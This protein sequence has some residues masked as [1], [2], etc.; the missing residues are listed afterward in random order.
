MENGRGC[1]S[2]IPGDNRQGL[3]EVAVVI[4]MVTRIRPTIACVAFL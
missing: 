1:G 3:H 4:A 2:K